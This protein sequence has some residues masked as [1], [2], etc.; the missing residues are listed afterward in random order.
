MTAKIISSGEGSWFLQRG[1][2][3]VNSFFT[4]FTLVELPFLC[5]C[6]LCRPSSVL[7]VYTRHGVM[8]SYDCTMRLNVKKTIICT[9]VNLGVPA[10]I[11]VCL[12]TA[13][14]HVALSCIGGAFA[15]QI[16]SNKNLLMWCCIER[17]LF[18][19]FY[20]IYSTLH[21]FVSVAVRYLTR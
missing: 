8:G 1:W 14:P 17:L 6:R 18:D 15:I 2:R 3:Y 5:T 11:Y 16:T 20:N 13:D 21:W 9:Y 4:T 10:F 19:C 12:V 7:E